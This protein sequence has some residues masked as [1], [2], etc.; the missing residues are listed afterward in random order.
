MLGLRRV[1]PILLSLLYVLSPLDLVPDVLPG[2]GW[3]DDLLVIGALLWY[4][5]AKTPGRAPWDVFGRM[6]W[7]PRAPGDVRPEDLRADFSQVDPY[8]LLEVPRGASADEIK[9]A[10]KRAVAR[11]HPDKVAHLGKEFQ[12]LAHRKLLA[13]QHAYEAIQGGRR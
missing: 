5:S 7:R 3:V 13:I 11:Y 4:L 2:V 10:Y 9:S 6:G 1:L 12:E 8:E